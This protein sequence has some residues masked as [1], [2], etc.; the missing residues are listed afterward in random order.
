MAAAHCRPRSACAHYLLRA[1]PVLLPLTFGVTAAICVALHDG[2]TENN[3]LR[4]I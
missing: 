3:V 1:A 4:Q 2:Q